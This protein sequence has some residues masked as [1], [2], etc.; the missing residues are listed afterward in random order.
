MF[1]V[2]HDRCN[3]LGLEGQDADR[4]TRRSSIDQALL[5][6]TE[7]QPY[8]FLVSGGAVMNPRSSI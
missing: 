1:D 7:A 8:P 6:P 2:P 5:R 4:H 3:T